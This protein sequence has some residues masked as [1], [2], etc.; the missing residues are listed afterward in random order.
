MKL[1]IFT[2]ASAAVITPFREK[3]I[4]FDALELLLNRQ[5]DAGCEAVTI[6]GTTGE[7]STLTKDEYIDIIKFTKNIVGDNCKVIAGSGTND[8]A[9]AVDKSIT[10]EI[11][12]ADA[13]LVVTPYYNKTSQK[14]LISHYLKIASSVK[15]PI[16]L[17][18]VPGRTGMTFTPETYKVLS[19]TENINGTKEASGNFDLIKKTKILC[20]DDLHIWSGN[21]NETLEIM[22]LGG[23][24]VISV[25]ANLIPEV[26][27]KITDICDDNEYDVARELV[28]K[29]YAL[30]ENMFIDI[31]P[32]PIKE[33]LALN[34]DCSADVRLP[35]V[36]L[37]KENKE[38]LVKTYNEYKN[39]G[40]I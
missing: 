30:I 14:G 23:K 20:N 18:N 29:Y 32:I 36:S 19:E 16:I 22:A 1:P 25:A 12:G 33:M 37:S 3:N 24:G 10:A 15:L 17:Y 39:L 34:G 28:Y 6:C 13:L 21:D 27:M 40:L 38:R 8:T 26:M 35:L 11:N 7:G 9:A 5:I 2:G 4:D 31:N